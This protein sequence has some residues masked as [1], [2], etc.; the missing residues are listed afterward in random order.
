MLYKKRHRN[1][2]LEIGKNQK[3]EFKYDRDYYNNFKYQ[4][5]EKEHKNNNFQHINL[6][7][8]QEISNCISSTKEETK[9]RE[10]PGFYFDYE[11][12][13]YFPNKNAHMNTFSN[14]LSIKNDKTI[15]N[16]KFE[17]K[18]K[19]EKS[20]ETKLKQENIVSKEKRNLIL[21]SNITKFS[22]FSLVSKQNFFHK[23][24]LIINNK[25][26]EF[27]ENNCIKNF[28]VKEL[29]YK[30]RT[31]KYEFTA[32]ENKKFLFTLDNSEEISRIL[33]EYIFVKSNSEVDYNPIREIKFSYKHKIF[34]SFKIVNNCLF[35][36]CEYDL[37]MVRLN[38]IFSLTR[39]E[40]KIYHVNLHKYLF[41]L[42]NIPL[43]FDW[44]L[45]KKKSRREFIILFYKSKNKYIIV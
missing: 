2:N 5:S 14:F 31:N 16:K 45:I 21:H 8:V 35:I 22:I 41:K 37:F 30:V 10:I 28:S 24:S 3:K 15:E 44:P 27:K 25:L 43:T 33:I 11:K 32:Y 36:Y 23:N 9:V 19:L 39:D 38:E 6:N 18:I 40:I 7:R 1:K 4:E 34:S 29:K 20:K 17:Q 26:K 42:K 12:N 13:R